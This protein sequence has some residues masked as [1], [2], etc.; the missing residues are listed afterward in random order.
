[1]SSHNLRAQ[2]IRLAHQHP[3]FRKDLLPLVTASYEQDVKQDADP[4][5]KDQSKDD[6][7]NGLN[8]KKPAL[9]DPALPSKKADLDDD[10]QVFQRQHP[11]HNDL[12]LIASQD[13]TYVGNGPTQVPWTRAQA[14]VRGQYVNVLE[15]RSGK[16][17]ELTSKGEKSLRESQ[18]A[19]S[20][21]GS[22]RPKSAAG[23]GQS[24]DDYWNG[25]EPKK[26][27][28]DEPALPPKQAGNTIHL[29]GK[30]GSTLCGERLDPRTVV[31][32]VREATCYYCGIAWE[33]ENGDLPL[34]ARV[35]MGIRTAAWTNLPPGW[36][37]DSV[38]SFWDT[39][40]G[41]KEHKITECISKMK[42]NVDNP[43]AFCGSLASQVGY[44]AASCW[45]ATAFRNTMIRLAHKNPTL[46]AEILP[47]IV[48]K[49]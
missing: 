41:S 49:A 1:M 29:P 11:Y 35:R 14:L 6:H 10:L 39:M 2:I 36:T 12:D 33:K 20:K 26:P 32:T 37:Q 18:N 24:A 22:M 15:D 45:D 42:D 31:A 21:L 40:T 48:R 38:Q 34:H 47:H 17:L 23:E 5:S 44:R 7:W 43:G 25:L 28:I 3:E 30:P 46:R 4:K 13:R 9:G 19:F 16:I 8:P 27:A